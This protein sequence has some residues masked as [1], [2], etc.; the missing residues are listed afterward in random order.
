MR[1]KRVLIIFLSI[2]LLLVATVFVVGKYYNNE[3]KEF[4]FAKINTRLKA[5]LKVEDMELT[6]FEHFPQA[7]LRF[8]NVTIADKLSKKD[9]LL[10]AEKL[11]LSFNFWD[12]WDKNYKVTS[13]KIDGGMFH[14]A[15]NE[16]GESNLDI[17]KSDANAKED[18]NFR[19]ALNGVDIENLFFRFT[20]PVNDQSLRVF[21]KSGQLN[22][23]FSSNKYNL[24][25]NL[26]SRVYTYSVNGVNYLNNKDVTLETTLK[27]D[28]DKQE[29]LFQSVK[30]GVNTVSLDLNG[31]IKYGDHAEM[32]L[33]IYGKE[34]KILDLVASLP[35]FSRETI[36]RYEA[37]GYLTIDS[38]L[39]GSLAKGQLPQFS[40]KFQIDNADLRD[41]V[42]NISLS[43]L[44]LKGTYQSGF[45]GND[46]S[47]NLKHLNGRFSSGS[48]DITGYVANFSQP[49]FSAGVKGVLDLNQLSQFFHWE[50]A[51]TL[52]GELTLNAHLKGSLDQTDTSGL[53][54]IN[55]IQTS[56]SIRLE[57]GR[58]KLRDSRDAMQDVNGDL[59]LS[60]NLAMVKNFRFHTDNSDFLVNG[61]IKNLV[62]YIVRKSEQLSVEASLISGKINL[63]DFI[64]TKSESKA[65]KET[66]I[67]F[68]AGVSGTLTAKIGRLVYHKFAADQI[69]G[70][71]RINSDGLIA[72]NLDLRAFQGRVTGSLAVKRANGKFLLQNQTQLNNTALDQVFYQFDNFGQSI[73]TSKEIKGKANANITV[74]GALNDQLEFLQDQ[75]KSTVQIKIV[76][77]E[78]NNLEVLQDLAAYLKTNTAIN[79]VVNCN[80]LAERLKKVSFATLENTL[81]IHDKKIVIPEMTIKSSAL[82]INFNG[83]H[84]FDNKIDYGLN[85]RMAEVF[86]KN[87][88]TEFGYIQDDNTGLRM[89][90]AIGGTTA[91][92]TFK[93][94]RL[95]AA[96]ARKD[97][98]VQEKS[99][100]K[101]IL[102]QEFG[103]FKSDT[104][105]K[106]PSSSQK[107]AP[108]FE[109]EYENKKP[110]VTATKPAAS[111]GQTTTKPKETP[112]EA[113]KKKPA[114]KET[115]DKDYNL[116]DDL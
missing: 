18:D 57:N 32:D 46:D 102:K 34:I 25:T 98:F 83:T 17:W 84:S 11:Y 115:D 35:D 113:P 42:N 92:P 96:Q 53:A 70:K 41:K 43:G 50:V 7:S 13:M 73:L 45:R 94:D 33:G 29:I 30:L 75:L 81:T 109:L 82:D 55:Q 63:E 68:P 48:F 90:I 36:D 60:E 40:S 51:D 72:E 106:A 105:L 15:Y 87:E 77:G 104:S 74:S 93:Y 38:R 54:L 91:N 66:R 103:L 97:K 24:E 8:S 107:V 27:I 31:F 64:E 39:K 52:A 26:N 110:A 79:T 10:F 3:V 44:T 56:G 14:L 21:I 1:L 2:I 111:P 76:D 59:T 71:I 88:V 95:S 47:L 86:K 112:K 4:V 80:K 37:N 116:D 89:F 100:F 85:F 61:I 108:R 5:P 23:D 62:P 12:I 67:N 114:K 20:Q 49:R 28:N 78:L 6:F 16:N 99:T 65:K 22:G 58:F 9:T 101:S 19:L 69:S